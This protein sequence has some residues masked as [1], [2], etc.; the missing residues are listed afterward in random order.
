[1]P[2]V[3]WH[4]CKWNCACKVGVLIAI[5]VLVIRNK[6][7]SPK[8]IFQAGLTDFWVNPNMHPP[9][10]TKH[11][12][13]NMHWIETLL[14]ITMFQIEIQ[15][16]QM[17]LHKNS[18]RL[19]HEGSA[20]MSTPDKEK[21]QELLPCNGVFVF[22]SWQGHELMP[23]CLL[24]R[25]T[26]WPKNYNFSFQTEADDSLQTKRR[27]WSENSKLMMALQFPS[28]RHLCKSEIADGSASFANLINSIQK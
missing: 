15:S 3:K 8:I 2:I 13:I 16:D 10:R 22:W 12:V 20:T 18:K 26:R 9:C 6:E 24:C 21:K 11:V 7:S 14:K 19:F 1:M 4:V 17:L 5:E 28:R 27:W 23:L 25:K